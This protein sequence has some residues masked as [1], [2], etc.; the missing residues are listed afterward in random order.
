MKTTITDGCFKALD[1]D[2]N[3]HILVVSTDY[4]N[5]SHMQ[6]QGSISLNG[7]ITKN[8]SPVKYVSKGKYETMYGLKLESA[9]PQAP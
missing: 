4:G 9:D 6:G 8:G 1:E 7:G 5:T 3:E 2:G